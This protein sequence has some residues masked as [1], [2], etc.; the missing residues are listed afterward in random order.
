MK[1]ALLINLTVVVFSFCFFTACTMDPVDVTDTETE[2][3]EEEEEAPT[4]VAHTI[5]Y[6]VSSP[7]D[8]W[9]YVLVTNETGGESFYSDF[10]I[11]STTPWTH[12][13]TK[14]TGDYVS[15]GLMHTSAEDVTASIYIDDVLFK[16][17]FIGQNLTYSPGVVHVEASGYIP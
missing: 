7:N 3:T 6:E 8:G 15:I 5:R 11:T 13:I 17:A 9:V 14:Y 10:S 4:P 12:S 1:K 16:Y 2:E